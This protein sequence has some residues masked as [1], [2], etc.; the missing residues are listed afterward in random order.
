[1]SEA[2]TVKKMKAKPSEEIVQSTLRLP[3]PL[4]RKINHI[5]VDKRLSMA[6]AVLEAISEYCKRE[7]AK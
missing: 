6:Q 7:E 2:P 5:A 1:V 3:R 4:W